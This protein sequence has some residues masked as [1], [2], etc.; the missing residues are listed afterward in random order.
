MGLAERE[1]LRKDYEY[2]KSISVRRRPKLHLSQTYDKLKRWSC[3][4]EQPYRKLRVDKLLS[5]LGMAIGLALILSIIVSYS[6]TLNKIAIRFIELGTVIALVVLYFILKS[7]YN[8]FVILKQAVKGLSNGAKL[9]TILLVVAL[10]L[11]AYQ[12][13]NDL[14]LFDSLALEHYFDTSSTI[15]TRTGISYETELGSER[16]EDCENL[17]FDMT[18]AE[19]RAQGLP[20]LTFD[21][22]LANVAREHSVDM[23]QNDFFSHTNLK[24]ED[25]TDRARRHGLTVIK[26][27]GGG[28]YMVGI[29]ENIG[30]M[31]KGNLIEMGYGANEPDGLATAQVQSWLNSSGHRANIL[32]PRFEKLGVGVAY[33]GHYYVSTQNFQ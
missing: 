22:A 18:N 5:N 8:V 2:T 19:R 33:N 21:P 29:A 23:A 28:I 16:L 26:R 30:M 24:G 20:E 1:Y 17:I 25:P 13:Q 14:S 32:N 10:S 27:T 31:P 6:D 4:R 7:L 15:E 12:I 11:Q 9:L 3:Q